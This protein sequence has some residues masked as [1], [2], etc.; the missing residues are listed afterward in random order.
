MR[1]PLHTALRLL[2]WCLLAGL[3]F[4]TLA[5]LGMR[6]ILGP[7][8]L[9]RA[10]AYAGFGLVAALAYPRQRMFVLAAVVVVAGLLEYGQS[11]TA[12]RHGRLADFLVKA[13]GGAAGWLAAC[14]LLIAARRPDREA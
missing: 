2:F 10:L 11:L 4:V 7:A 12:S 9:E 14:A 6:P 8:N 5:P 3:A 1:P 13:A